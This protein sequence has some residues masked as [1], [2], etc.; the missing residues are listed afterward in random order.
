M[1]IPLAIVMCMITG[2]PELPTFE[3]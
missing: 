3:F 2:I 1:L